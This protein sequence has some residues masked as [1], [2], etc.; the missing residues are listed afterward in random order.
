MNLDSSHHRRWLDA[1]GLTFEGEPA[2]R[3]SLLAAALVFALALVV[4][5]P[6]ASAQD[7][8]SLEGE[9]RGLY[10]AAVSAYDG[11]R[12]E[13]ALRYF[14]MSFERSGRSALLYNIAS[15]AERT[16]DDVLALQSYEAFLE[17]NPGSE[18]RARVETRIEVLRNR[19]EAR[20]AA[21]EAAAA[22]PTEPVEPVVAAPAGLDLSSA[23]EPEPAAGASSVGPWVVTG[24]GVATLVVGGAL[25]AIGLGDRARVEGADDG[26]RWYEGA[27][28]AYD[29]GPALLTTGVV[30][31]PLGALMAAGGVVWLV[32]KPKGDDRAVSVQLGPGSFLL[33][34]EF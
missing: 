5:G 24:A 17:A 4:A 30:L 28:R 23:P 18:I 29:R 3:R 31:A 34:G 9:A 14:Q 7:D 16:Q 32:S 13:E 20:R 19:L 2:A 26:D 10:Q 12:Y 22:A 25:I 21:E 11:G 1:T 27:D 6:I 8:A 15:T 33:R